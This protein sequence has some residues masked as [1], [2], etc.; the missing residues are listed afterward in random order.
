MHSHL[1]DKLAG[2]VLALLLLPQSLWARAPVHFV[3]EIGECASS[4][5][6]SKCH[7]Y[8]RQFPPA[9]R[10]WIHEKVTAEVRKTLVSELPPFDFES[11][12]PDVPVLRA[13][14]VDGPIA[15]G[16]SV[17]FS[18]THDGAAESVEFEYRD[19]VHYGAP[20]PDRDAF[21]QELV[22][23]LSDAIRRQRQKIIENLLS[24]LPVSTGAL[25]L[26]TRKMF[27]LTFSEDD[28][29]IGR[30]SKF[31]IDALGADQLPLEF[32]TVS[33]GTA[34]KSPI[35]PPLYESK[36]LT[37]AVEPDDSIARLQQG[38]AFTLGEVHLLRYVPAPDRRQPATDLPVR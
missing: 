18:L 5:D 23:R 30:E 1:P 31:R 37:L 36:V 20:I 27:V 12:A 28:M 15:L 29:K 19:A 21:A 11:S 2:I 38:E 33:R 22:D 32:V 4:P 34:Q 8:G 6:A 9:D 35:I 25:P 26:P 10:A 14:L 3:F 24:A 7:P 17:V 13:R 16:H